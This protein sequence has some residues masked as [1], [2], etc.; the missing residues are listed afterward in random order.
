MGRREATALMLLFSLVHAACVFGGEAGEAEGD[1]AEPTDV[2]GGSGNGVSLNGASLN[3]RFLNGL[4]LNGRFLNGRFLNGIELNGRFLNG[5]TLDG[6]GLVATDGTTPVGGEELVGA[7]FEAGVAD[8]GSAVTLRIEGIDWGEGDRADVTYYWFSY[9]G[10][11][12]WRPVCRDS[13]G[14]AVPAILLA[15]RW[16]Y[17]Q[18]VEGGGSRIDDPDAVTI[19]CA[20]AALAKCVE[21][22]YKPWDESGLPMVDLHQSCTRMLRADYCGNGLPSTTDGWRINVW[23]AYGVQTTDSAWDFRFDAEWAPRGAVCLRKQRV[24]GACGGLDCS[25]R[26]GNLTECAAAI[27]TD[28]CGEAFEPGSYLMDEAWQNYSIAG[29]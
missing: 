28:D 14:Q 11:S 7:Q 2:A 8:D 13:W 1:E 3:G 22:G 9:R 29:G 24:D 6:S 19:A 23:D 10:R 17:R 12:D 16:D 18:G 25:P 26:N 27:T 21:L 5:A 20:G 4:Y 15:G